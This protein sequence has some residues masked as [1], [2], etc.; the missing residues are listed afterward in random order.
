MRASVDQIRDITLDAIEGARD[1]ASGLID[2]G[3]G[4]LTSGIDAKA[5]RLASGID[6][7]VEKT[8]VIAVEVAKRRRGRRTWIALALALV[9]GGVAFAVLRRKGAGAPPEPPAAVREPVPTPA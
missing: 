6:L 3:A 7:F 9:V 5:D 2:A 1:Q 4:R 8:P